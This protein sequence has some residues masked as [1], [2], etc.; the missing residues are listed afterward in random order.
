MKVIKTNIYGVLANEALAAFEA[1]FGQ[2]PADYAEFISEANG[3]ELVSSTVIQGGDEHGEAEWWGVDT[4]EGI[5]SRKGVEGVELQTEF[6]H[7]DYPQGVI[8]VAKDGSGNCYVMALQGDSRG[9]I[10]FLDHELPSEDQQD[11]ER[12]HRVADNFAGFVARIRDKI[13]DDA[14][15]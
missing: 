11:I 14:A 4:I 7:E 3:V 5:E 15:S 1:K 10:F 13:P 8:P 9:A 6:W 12:L 2:I